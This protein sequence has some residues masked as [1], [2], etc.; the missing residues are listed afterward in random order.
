[1]K[2]ITILGAAAAA[3]I[4]AG[5]ITAP[6]SARGGAANGNGF[7]VAAASGKDARSN[8]GGATRGLSRADSVA[9]AH[10]DK[11][12]DRAAANKTKPKKP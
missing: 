1:M 4:A 2:H 8:K 12:R 10:G 7:T 6:A 9:G 11:G 5:G 3:V